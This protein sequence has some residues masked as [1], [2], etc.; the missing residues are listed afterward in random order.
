MRFYTRRGGGVGASFGLIGLVM[1]G[2][3]YLLL[4][5]VAAALIAPFVVLFVI[6]LL[7]EVADGLLRVV[8]AYRRRR[9]DLGPVRWHR[10]TL[11]LCAAYIG[12]QVN[13]LTG[14]KKRY[15]LH[16][17]AGEKQSSHPG[18]SSPE[19]IET[20]GADAVPDSTRQMK[21]QIALNTF[22]ALDGVEFAEVMHDL[23]S[24]K[25]FGRAEVVP[26]AT[27]APTAVSMVDSD[28]LKVI[29]QCESFMAGTTVGVKA[30]RDAIAAM[31]SCGASQLAIVSLNP[32]TAQAKKLAR[33]SLVVLYDREKLVDIAEEVGWLKTSAES[34]P[35]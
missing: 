32:F 25:E 23:F 27:H 5:G 20:Q 9:K 31:K 28:G 21:R 1:V 18:S 3:F 16:A 8:P 2:F 14:S 17:Q 29:V 4:A 12:N 11:R 15:A 13:F 10:K 22:L 19:P 7:A 30:L 6:A 24:A 26:G 35:A 33:T 34:L